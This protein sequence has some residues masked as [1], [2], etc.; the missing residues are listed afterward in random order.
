MPPAHSL[1]QIIAPLRHNRTHIFC[2]G[3][4]SYPAHRWDEDYMPGYWVVSSRTQFGYPGGR[5][6]MQLAK[7]A[8]NGEAL[9]PAGNLTTWT[10]HQP[11][12]A[13]SVMKLEDAEPETWNPV[14][15]I[16]ISNMLGARE[17]NFNIFWSLSFEDTNEE[18]KRLLNDPKLSD[19]TIAASTP[20][21]SGLPGYH[22]G[23]KLIMVEGGY[24]VGPGY[25]VQGVTGSTR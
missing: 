1:A 13:V 25:R 20:Y 9:T 14:D 6:F 8:S 10:V 12:Y 18:L 3:T 15:T 5:R 2:I 24:R 4:D 21:V 22:V 17:Y 16:S 19:E 23:W 7:T 11:V